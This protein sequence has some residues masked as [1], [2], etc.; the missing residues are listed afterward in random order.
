MNLQLE[1]P[2]LGAVLQ[3]I[4]T[5]RFRVWA[6]LVP[7]VSL[8]LLRGDRRISLEPERFGY[9]SALVQDA[10]PGD[11]YLL[12]IGNDRVRPDPASRFQPEGVHGPSEVV[13]T[14][15][16]WTDGDWNSPT[17]DDFVIYELHI[18]TFTP[19]GTFDAAIADLD[20]LR[21][22]GVTAVEL[23][24]VAQFPGARN[25]GYDGVY[26]FAVQASYGGP[27]KLKRF[28]DACH[29]R[30]LAVI[31][32]VVY[33]HL[34][35]EGN[36]LRD[37]GPYF[38]DQYRT[39]WGEALNFDGPSSD[40]V[41]EFFLAN[42]AM[43]QTEFHV[44]ALRL[45]AVHA[46]KDASAYPFLAELADFTARRALELGRRFH[47]FAESDLNDTRLVR[48][49][50]N[51]GMGMGAMWSDDYHHALHTLLTGERA[52]YYE[53]FGRLEDLALAYQTGFTFS[54]QHSGYRDRR[55]GNTPAG[56][57]PWR[58]VVSSQNHDQVGNRAQ[59][60]RLG[61][62]CD[63]ESQK[64][65]A[66]LVLLSPFIPLLFMGEEFGETAPFLYFVSHGD[67]A[68]VDAVRRGRRDEFA[69][70]SWKGEVPDP[71]DEATFTRSKL[72]RGLA[73]AGRG[74][75]LHRLYH[76]LIRLRTTARALARCGCSTPDLS[77]DPSGCILVDRRA[78]NARAALLFNL[79][80]SSAS[81]QPSWTGEP[82]LKVFD[83]SATCWDGP[84]EELPATFIPG[85]AATLTVPRRSFAVFFLGS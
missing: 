46:I 85:N 74:R 50:H 5:C 37:F 25:W 67:P 21:S 71:Q 62:L 44:D 84:G 39:P 18:G 43:W 19:D 11:R 68:L 27:T 59:G 78:G 16:D 57:E 82:W 10:Q 83:S 75:I 51:G 31:L 70:F 76:E 3:A 22:L 17:L 8:H 23:M 38:T 61:A 15:F 80:D 48:P 33:N 73:H 26:P 53:D 6:P 56:L 2:E 47:L 42:A 13:G 55:H 45:D 64:L 20:R 52:G 69:R 1:P 28:V 34:G 29:A 49:S 30:G 12:E 9:H 54:G 79:G 60:E 4:G 36:Y 32:D 81:V 63:W 66:G 65:A 77:V 58:F 35:P 40:R 14:S 41:R 24:P 7:R 72:N